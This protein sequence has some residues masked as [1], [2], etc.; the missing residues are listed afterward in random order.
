MSKTASVMQVMDKI[1]TDISCSI[2][3]KFEPRFLLLN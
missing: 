1:Y 3:L 2:G